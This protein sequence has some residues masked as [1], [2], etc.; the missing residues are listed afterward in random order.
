MAD[1]GES[2]V[3][4]VVSA[5]QRRDVGVTTVVAATTFVQLMKEIY[6]IMIRYAG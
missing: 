4:I 3:E 2:I 1:G 6:K 5:G